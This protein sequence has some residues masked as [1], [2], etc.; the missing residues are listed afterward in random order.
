MVVAEVDG[1]TVEADFG[2][3]WTA[4]DGVVLGVV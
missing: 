1:V 2:A 3:G 4:I